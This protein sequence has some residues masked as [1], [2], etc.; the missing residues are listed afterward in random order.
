VTLRN[1]ADRTSA[2]LSARKAELPC[3]CQWKNE[4]ALAD[5]YVTGLEFGSGYPT[6]RRQERE[7]G[8]LRPLAPGENETTRLSFE[9]SSVQ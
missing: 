4:V 7:A 8:R 2:T 1:P 9:L 3:F 5:G 6:G